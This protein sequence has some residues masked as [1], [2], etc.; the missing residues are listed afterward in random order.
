MRQRLKDV[1]AILAGLAVIYVVV[2]WTLI[3]RLRHPEFT[4]TQL[5]LSFW[6]AMCWR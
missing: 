3:Y 6:D 5:F 4:E 1:L 2:T